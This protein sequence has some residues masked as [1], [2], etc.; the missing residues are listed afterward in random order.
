MNITE[1]IVELLQK[2]QKVELPGIGTFDSEVQAPRHDPATRVYYPATRSIVY[3]EGTSGDESLV[4]VIA[5]RECV[6][7]E[8]AHQ[9]WRNYLDALTDKL[10]RTGSHTFGELGTLVRSGESF[11]FRMAEGLVIGATGDEKPLE[12][13]RTYE[14]S[15][16][17]DPFAQFEE[18]PQAPKPDPKPA[19]N[20]KP[21][22]EPEPVPEPQPEPVPSPEP[23]PVPEPEPEP[24]IIPEP[25]PEPGIP[26]ALEHSEPEIVP[27]PDSKPQETSV[28]DEWKKAVQE[29]DQAPVEPKKKSRKWLLWLLLL[30]VVLAAGGYY[31]FSQCSGSEEGTPAKSAEP[32]ASV[33]SVKHLDVPVTNAFTFNG[34]MIAYSGREIAGNVEVVCANMADY[35]NTY[36]AAHNYATARV[37]MMDRVRQYAAARMGVLLGDRFAM[38]RFIPYEDYIYQ[39]S[40][41]WLKG[42]YA[43]MACHTVQG[44]LMNAGLLGELLQRLIDDLGIEPSAP[45]RTAAE[46]QQVKEAERTA[47]AARVT[48]EV[49]VNVEKASKQG[50]DIIAG[51]YLNRATAAKLTARLAEQGCDAYIIE[52]NDMFYVSMGSA[53]TRTKAEALYNHIKS[54]YDG[55]IAIK[56]L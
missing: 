18:A 33:T 42:N 23:E 9:M 39:F 6:S 53:P 4:S 22:P 5:Q 17:D 21:E 43:N 16:N 41:P 15:D 14:H 11:V 44:E 50:F 2:G 32:T 47:Q 20:P 37:P 48:Q 36:L 30:L 38:Q 46:V 35:V 29:M 3:R 56:E 25:E 51:F 27:E 55:D 1:L 19:P 45:I 40:E 52:K 12:E 26:E 28:K 49:P 7:E 34:D 31:Y 10:S 24:D 8:V 13:V 54:W